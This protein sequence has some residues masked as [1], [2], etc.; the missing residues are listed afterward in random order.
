VKEEYMSTIHEHCSEKVQDMIDSAPEEVWEQLENK[1][2]NNIKRPFFALFMTFL[3]YL[4][5]QEFII[6]KRKEPK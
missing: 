1:N 4:F 2:R 6:L 5:T 3:T